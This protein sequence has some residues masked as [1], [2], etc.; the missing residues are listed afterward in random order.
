MNWN[1]SE[2]KIF[3]IFKNLQRQHKYKLR[4]ASHIFQSDFI[5]MSGK[6]NVGADL[7]NYVCNFRNLLKTVVH[8]LFDATERQSGRER[9][10]ETLHNVCKQMRQANAHAH[11]RCVFAKSVSV[12][13]Y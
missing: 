5:K 11:C 8:S 7:R 10:R 12:L 2:G 6:K 4:L 13:A 1:V 3:D 9:E